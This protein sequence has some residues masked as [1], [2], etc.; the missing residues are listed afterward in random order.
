MGHLLLYRLHEAGGSISYICVCGKIGRA[1][2][3]YAIAHD[4]HTPMVRH[5]QAK[6]TWAIGEGKGVRRAG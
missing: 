1:A 4:S 5:R 6:A 2:G 3:W